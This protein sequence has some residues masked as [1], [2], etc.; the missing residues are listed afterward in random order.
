MPLKQTATGDQLFLQASYLLPST[1]TA[2]SFLTGMQRLTAPTSV[3]SSSVLLSL[4]KPSIPVAGPSMCQCTG[5]SGHPS[6][7]PTT[8]HILAK[9]FRP[10][11]PVYAGT[12]S[13]SLWHSTASK[14]CNCILK[15]EQANSTD[16]S[17]LKYT[18]SLK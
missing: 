1:R 18:I 12:N 3:V 9:I 15:M 4:G 16:L 13:E 6:A 8:G 10:P 11:H 5:G 14:C 17:V 7:V 2:L